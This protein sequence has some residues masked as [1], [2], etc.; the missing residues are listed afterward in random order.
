V[1]SSDL[2]TIEHALV[3]HCSLLLAHRTDVPARLRDSI[4]Y[5]L[6]APGKRIRPLLLIKTAQLLELDSERALPAACALEMIHC[7]TLIH[8]DLPCLDNDD[9]RRG[10]PSNHRQFDEATALLAGDALLSLAFE[11][12]CLT[13]GNP[14]L[15]LPAIARLA[16]VSGPAGVCGGQVRES[17][18]DQK[19]QLSDL[20]LMHALKTGALFEAALL[21]PADLLG[22]G[23]D[24]SRYQALHAFARSLGSA[25]QI[26]DD[27][28]D[29]DQD[30]GRS[31]SIL[32]HLSREEASQRARQELQKSCAQL[33]SVFGK[34]A[35]SLTEIADSVLETLQ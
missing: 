16:K 7:F 32:G 8:D 28:G 2:Q 3:R 25:F 34:K 24:D 11:T 14:S 21:I 13:P 22:L 4:E 5:S 6:L 33:T 9:L 29:A 17:G 35:Q 30:E 27:L 23:T 15:L 19:S 31:V 10:R 20:Q 26:A 1:S 18:L 12:L